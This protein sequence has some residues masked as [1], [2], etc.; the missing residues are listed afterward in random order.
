MPQGSIGLSEPQRTWARIGVAETVEVEE[1]GGQAYLG[2]MDVEIGFAGKR[3]TEV[4]YDQDE[5]ANAVKQVRCLARI[6]R[7]Q[8]LT[9]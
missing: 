8:I 4:P 7:E 2:A 3:K 9:N 5:L 1:Y 6:L